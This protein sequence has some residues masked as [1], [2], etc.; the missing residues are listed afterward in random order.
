VL[1]YKA[2][3]ET[4]TRFLTCLG[5]ILVVLVFFVHH[6]EGILPAK[7][8]AYELMFYAHSYLAAL[9]I[10]SVILLGMGGLLH[11]RATGVSSFTPALPV[12]RERLVMVRAAVSVSQAVVLGVVPWA[13]MLLTSLWN[14]RPFLISQ[15]CFYVFL[16]I[17]GGLVC[18]A[19]AIFVS[20]LVEGE[21]TAPAVAYGAIVLA[22]IVCGTVSKLRPFLDL[23]RFVSAD[24]Y[25]NRSA[26]LLSGPFPWSGIACCGCVAA[27]LILASVRVTRNRDFWSRRLHENTL[28]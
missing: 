5:F 16:L 25:Y 13:A 23:W 14:G 20:S 15:A 7:S 9:W 21:Y 24:C 11:E 18:L 2:W 10:L 27:I 12:S 8:D 1:W 6:A 22:S 26:H 4:R 19:S 3:L 17:G 28:G